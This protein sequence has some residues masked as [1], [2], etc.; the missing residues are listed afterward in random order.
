MP[1]TLN[2]L[3]EKL[4]DFSN[5]YQI[6]AGGT[7]IFAS[8]EVGDSLDKVGLDISRIPELTSCTINEGKSIFIGSA[9]TIQNFIENPI[10]TENLPVARLA[11]SFFADEQI[12][13]QATV[14]GNIVN[15]SPCADMVPPLM[16][17]NSI[18]HTVFSS[19][20]DLVRENY[21]MDGFITGLG[22]TKLK[23]GHVVTGIECPI[24]DGYGSSFKKVGTRRSLA[25][26]VINAAFLVKV[27]EQ[28]NTFEDLRI[29]YFGIAP[30]PLRL[31]DCES[32]LIGKKVSSE[33]IFS[34]LSLI[35]HD[36]VQSRSRRE[37]RNNV[38]K[39]S[40]IDGMLESLTDINI[41]V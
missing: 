17:L 11:A 40:F 25:V 15:A 32:F 13:R 33:N 2:E 29:C 14:G 41:S 37:Y 22:K 4:H 35:P 16:T 19:G 6:I 24:I 8:D 28:N 36:I 27:D 26:S 18:V 1:E 5:N 31:T 12:R 9:L 10:L 39:N 7:D 21:P 3:F 34:A 30:I 38:V 20:G 23:Q